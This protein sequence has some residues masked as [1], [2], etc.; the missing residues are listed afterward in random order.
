MGGAKEMSYTEQIIGIVI[1]GICFL[2]GLLYAAPITIRD[3]IADVK[4]LWEDL[5][6]E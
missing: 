1:I 6:N 3:A 2:V 5:K 4:E